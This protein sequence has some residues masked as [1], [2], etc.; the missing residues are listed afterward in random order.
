MQYKYFCSPLISITLL[1]FR[2]LLASFRWGLLLSLPSLY[3]FPFCGF[4]LEFFCKLVNHCFVS[5]FHFYGKLDQIDQFGIYLK[6]ITSLT[7][8]RILFYTQQSF[9]LHAYFVWSIFS[10]T[11]WTLTDA[12]WLCLRNWLLQLYWSFICK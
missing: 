3:H 11:C 10:P 4:F 2:I 8:Y 7:T 1:A 5:I 6:F 9:L 12:Q